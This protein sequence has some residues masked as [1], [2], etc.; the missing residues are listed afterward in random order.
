MFNEFMSAIMKK[1][2]Y[3]QPAVELMRLMANSTI[4]VGSDSTLPIGDPLSGEGGD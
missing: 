3:I 4:L 1:K 2:V